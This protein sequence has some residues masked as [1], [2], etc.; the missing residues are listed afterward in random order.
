MKKILSTLLVSFF[1]LIPIQVSFAHFHYEAEAT[2]VLKTN[3]DDK[4][5]ALD[6][7]WIYDP[8]VTDMMLKDNDDLKAF[9]K[10]LIK[11]LGKLGYITTLTLD[12]KPLKT[13]TVEKYTLEKIGK[14]EDT[15]LKLSFTLPLE[16]PTEIK[17]K[18][19]LLI[20]HTDPSAS[21]IIYY[22]TAMSISFDKTLDPHCIAD[23]KNK[24]DYAHGETPQRVKIFCE[25]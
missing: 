5:N 3:K 1:L 17:G 9:G 23:V 7:S 16:T 19:T 24:K 11:D 18:S 4:L 8:T 10:G 25:A 21:A 22:E 2:T 14:N 6:I 15:R 12:G 13:T 20:D